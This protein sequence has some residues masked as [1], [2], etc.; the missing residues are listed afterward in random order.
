MKTRSELERERNQTADKKE[1]SLIGIG[2]A[3]LIVIG[4]IAIWFFVS[5]TPDEKKPVAVGKGEV[6]TAVQCDRIIQLFRR[7]GIVKGERIGGR[8]NVDEKRWPLVQEENR[9]GLLNYVACAA[10]AG[11]SAAQLDPGTTVT[12]YGATSGKLLAKADSRAM[13]LFPE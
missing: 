9:R 6:L 13:I 12:V 1:T 8:V 11:R 2:G 10:F 5:A 4:A 3:I 7:D